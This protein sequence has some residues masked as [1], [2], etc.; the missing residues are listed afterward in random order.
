MNDHSS[1]TIKGIGA[2]PGI[3]IGKAYLLERGQIP[4]PRY[5]LLDEKAV[6]DECRRFEQAV[7]RAE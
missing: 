2:A 6:A 5:R 1:L 7:A 3:A 4:I